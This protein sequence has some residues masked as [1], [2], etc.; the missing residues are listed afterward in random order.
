MLVPS[1]LLHITGPGAVCVYDIEMDG[2]LDD[3]NGRILFTE[4]GS[5]PFGIMNLISLSEYNALTSADADN[6]VIVAEEQDIASHAL[7]QQ[8]GDEGFV[9]KYLQW[10]LVAVGIVLFV[11]LIFG[12]CFVTRKVRDGDGRNE[13]VEM[14]ATTEV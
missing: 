3:V 7:T 12:Y 6:A 13:K 11:A 4:T 9:G 10:I 8:H 1:Y 14:V 5:L 2:G